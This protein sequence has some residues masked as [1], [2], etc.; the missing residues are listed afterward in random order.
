MITFETSSNLKQ[1]NQTMKIVTNN[2]PRDIIYGNDLTET[3]RADYDWLEGD[4]L[5]EAS[6]FRFKGHLYCLSD[7]M[8]PSVTQT[9]GINSGLQC[10]DGYSADSFFLATVV[11][12]VDDYEQI[13]VG[14]VYS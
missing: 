4:E 13:V 10:W 1:E 12:Y 11:R 6:F 14:T 5:S 9:T 7:F 8:R 2:I 3:E